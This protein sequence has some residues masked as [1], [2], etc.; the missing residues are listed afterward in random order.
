M[1]AK[2]NVSCSPEDRRALSVSLAGAI[3][4]LILWLTPA[5]AQNFLAMLVKSSLT[6]Q[7]TTRPSRNLWSNLVILIR[8]DLPGEPRRQRGYWLQWRHQRQSLSWRPG[9]S[10]AE[11]WGWSLPGLPSSETRRNTNWGEV[12]ALWE[13]TLVCCR[14]SSINFFCMGWRG[15]LCWM[16]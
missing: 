11:H 16:Q 6:S 15:L 3:F 5:S 7:A 1:N 4:S 13:L 14:V 2:S 9:S 8:P 12:R 10:S